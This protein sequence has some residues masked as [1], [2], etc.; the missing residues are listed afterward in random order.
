M[1][2]MVW[3]SIYNREKVLNLSTKSRSHLK[4]EGIDRSV[5]DGFRQRIL[6]LVFLDKQPGYE[7]FCESE[8]IHYKNINKYYNILLK[9]R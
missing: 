2:I 6:F 7:V 1:L 8:T 9:K 3:P 5:L 4:C